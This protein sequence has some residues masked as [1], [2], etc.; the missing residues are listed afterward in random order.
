MPRASGWSNFCYRLTLAGTS[1]PNEAPRMMSYPLS[2]TYQDSVPDQGLAS[3]DP[4][5]AAGAPAPG[6]GPPPL[7]G[8]ELVDP[9]RSADVP[10][11]KEDE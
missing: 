5:L 6:S 9:S 11:R 1:R 3:L 4:N 8:P 7:A 10:D 2:L